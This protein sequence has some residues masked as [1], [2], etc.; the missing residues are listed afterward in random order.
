MDDLSPSDSSQIFTSSY[1]KCNATLSSKETCL[2]L[3]HTGFCEVQVTSYLEVKL[4]GGFHT[5]TTWAIFFFCIVQ[6]GSYK[7]HNYFKEDSLCF[8]TDVL[9]IYKAFKC[10]LFSHNFKKFIQ[11]EQFMPSLKKKKAQRLSSSW[12]V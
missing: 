11:N 4:T 9:H 12:S 6:M 1:S 5:M 3:S 10:T 2:Q 8:E 7:H